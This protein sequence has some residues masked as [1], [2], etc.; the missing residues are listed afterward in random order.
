MSDN[1]IVVQ[2]DSPEK[3]ASK[4]TGDRTRVIDLIL[5]NPN[6]ERVVINGVLTF[7]TMYLGEVLKLPES[8]P[9]CAGCAGKSHGCGGKVGETPAPTVSPYTPILIGL[10]ALTAGAGVAYIVTKPPKSAREIAANYYL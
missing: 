8:W 3:I 10:L 9:C 5:A 1:Y 6:K 2:G 4:K 7:R